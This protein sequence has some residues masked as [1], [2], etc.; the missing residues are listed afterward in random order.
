MADNYFDARMRPAV[1]FYSAIV[2][3]GVAAVLVGVGA[4]HWGRLASWFPLPGWMVMVIVSILLM[5]GAWRTWQ[6][7][8]I[9][10]YRR[11]LKRLP[12]WRLA[13]ERIPWSRERLFLGQGFAWGQAHSQR[14][15]EARHP[16]AVRYLRHGRAYRLARRFERG[17]EHSRWARGLRRLSRSRSRW[18]PVAPL[19]D[20]GGDPALHGVGL[21]E[22][23]PVEMSLVARAN[24]LFVPGTTG[25]GKTRLAEVLV[26]QD[27]RRGD[28]VFFFDPKGDIE[29]LI[30]M[31]YEAKQA[32]KLDRFYVFHLG[33]PEWSA[34][35][36]PVG[37]IGRITEVA[38][39]TTSPLPDQGNAAAFKEFAWLFANAVSQ[40]I[41][42]LGRKPDLKSIG[43]YVANIEPLLIEY[44]ELWLSKNGPADWETR[45]KAMASDENFPKRLPQAMKT[46][47][48]YAA[49][50]AVFQRELGHDDPVC[51][52]LRNTFEY[53]KGYFD[54]LSVSLRP[55]IEK[56]T[57]G[58][59]GALIAPDYHDPKDNRPVL[60][61]R[62]LIRE[63]A[64]VYVGLDTLSDQEVG[65]AVGAAM[66]AD[67]TS[68]AGQIYKHGIAQGLP[69]DKDDDKPT[70]Y[71][72]VDEFNEVVG[73][74]F[75]PMLNKAR[76]AGFRCTAYTQTLEDIEVRFGDQARAGQTVGN[77][78]NV[79]MLRVANERTAELITTR[80]PKV[81][82]Y[83]KLPETRTTDNNDPDSP[84]DFA[85]QYLDKIAEDPEAEMLSAADLMSLPIGQ[86][87]AVIE[88]G[89]V[90]KIRLPLLERAPGMP[91]GI[92]DI[93]GWAIKRWGLDDD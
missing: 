4:Q 39:R 25:V 82:A 92:A 41:V 65:S 9:L 56:L 42:G 72:H 81:R 71:L 6:A 40:A 30:R 84:V 68:V 7:V 11:G 76:G 66:F 90:R 88:G 54:K 77:M 12:L 14:L 67:M 31:F 55:L 91:D 89:Q 16:D 47:D 86:A 57:T 61:W 78:T 63:R 87:F 10:R 93:R 44:F 83:T 34:R 8:K 48:R 5:I 26:T 35:Y 22:E 19:P 85:S 70:I 3:F 62:K 29:M 43:R 80:L 59:V 15:L 46:R 58:P 13:D 75:V 33:F 32:G 37:E 36:N 1:E 45:V 50:L 74:E 51:E 17:T 52:N 27:I 64:I 20:L 18:N 60:D 23:G 49:A 53:E 2:Q 24:H 73:P 69:E 28:V 79:V 21:E 38:T